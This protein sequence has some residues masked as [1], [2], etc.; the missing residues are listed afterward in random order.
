[1]FYH[2]V[3]SYLRRIKSGI[4]VTL[5]NNCTN[6]HNDW[7]WTFNQIHMLTKYL[8]VFLFVITFLS[9]FYSCVVNN[10]VFLTTDL[11][12]KYFRFMLMYH[13][14]KEVLIH[15]PL[16]FST[17]IWDS[18]WQQKLTK[19]IDPLMLPFHKKTLQRTENIKSIK[20]VD[21]TLLKEFQVI[22]LRKNRI[23]QRVS[24]LRKRGMKN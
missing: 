4:I 18:P 23:R 10:K 20:C 16:F 9:R 7:Y 2:R 14:S 19:K 5:C 13:L 17:S 21:N 1:M 3:L 22:R 15:A 12:V 11:N 24:D 8:I 6:D